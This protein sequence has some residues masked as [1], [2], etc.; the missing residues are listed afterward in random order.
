MIQGNYWGKTIGDY[1]IGLK[2][3]IA[4]CSDDFFSYLCYYSVFVLFILQSFFD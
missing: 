1:G 3:R 2:Q 4:F